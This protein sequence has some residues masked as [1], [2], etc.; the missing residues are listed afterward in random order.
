VHA[1]ALRWVGVVL[2]TDDGL[3]RNNAKVRVADHPPESSDFR[4]FARDE[5]Y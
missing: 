5:Q 1:W 2:G 4:Q 3:S